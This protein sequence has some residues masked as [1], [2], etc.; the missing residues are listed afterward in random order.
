MPACG[1]RG[2]LMDQ[3]Q[4]ESEAIGNLVRATGG[5]TLAPGS[6][7]VGLVAVM[8][9][10]CS[11]SSTWWVKATDTPVNPAA[12]SPASYSLRESAPAMPPTPA[13]R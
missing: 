1:P 11:P 13:P 3:Q 12:V 4:P 6:A 10:E 2:P 9:A 7:G 8:M 5:A